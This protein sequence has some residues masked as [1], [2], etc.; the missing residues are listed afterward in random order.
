MITLLTFLFNLVLSNNMM[1][2]SIIFSFKPSGFS[3]IARPKRRTGKGLQRNNQKNRIDLKVNLTTVDSMYGGSYSPEDD[4]LLVEFGVPSSAFALRPA[5]GQVVAE[6]QELRIRDARAMTEMASSPHQ[7]KEKAFRCVVCTLPGGT[8]EHTDA[9]CAAQ[10][11]LLLEP[12]ERSGAVGLALG[13]VDEV[14]WTTTTTL[15]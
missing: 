2:F 10:S 1:K 14:I 15:V 7:G 6:A 3:E 12:S 4:D 8:C 11:S 13:G 5:I 9:W